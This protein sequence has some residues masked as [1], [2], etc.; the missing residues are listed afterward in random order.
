M[1][2][3]FCRMMSLLCPGPMTPHRA[4]QNISCRILLLLSLGL[5]FW[6]LFYLIQKTRNAEEQWELT[7]GVSRMGT[8]A[9]REGRFVV[10]TAGCTIPDVDPFDPSLR[11]IVYPGDLLICSAKPA[12]T[13][14]EGR[15]PADKPHGTV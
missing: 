13:Y 15:V 11:T 2:I 5:T 7:S 3:M 1:H 14:T 9:E 6:I 10:N 12:L 8:R 4:T